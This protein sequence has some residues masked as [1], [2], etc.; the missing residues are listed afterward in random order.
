M[1]TA[2]ALVPDYYEEQREAPRSKPAQPKRPVSNNRTIPKKTFL[3]LTMPNIIKMLAVFIMGVALVAQYA[4]IN[5]LGY[6]LNRSQEDLTAILTENERLK[7]EYAALGNLQVIEDYAVNNLGMVKPEG[8]VAYIPNRASE[9]STES[10]SVS[11][12]L[13]EEDGGILTALKGFLRSIGV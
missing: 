7:Q 10:L 4:Y 6:T 13:A 8:N 5:S 11:E 12:P 1:S 9:S 3:A 2:N